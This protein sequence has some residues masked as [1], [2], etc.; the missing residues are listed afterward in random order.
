MS[1]KRA[2]TI[3]LPASSVEKR[4]RLW[5]YALITIQSLKNA[6]TYPVTAWE[7]FLRIECWCRARENGLI[8]S[9]G[10]RGPDAMMAA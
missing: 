2:P 1:K 6:I 4:A 9:G 5:K 3:A 8:R 7:V 10:I